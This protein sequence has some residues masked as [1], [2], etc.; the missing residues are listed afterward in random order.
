MPRQASRVNK[1]IRKKVI[2]YLD[3]HDEPSNT[4]LLPEEIFKDGNGNRG[5]KKKWFRDKVVEDVK[6]VPVRDRGNV[7]RLSHQLGI[8]V[9]TVRRMKK[10]EGILRSHRSSIK[11]KLT[12]E[13]VEW[14][15]DYSW[16]K[17]D[18]EC[19]DGGMDLRGPSLYYQK[20]YNNIHVDEKWFYLIKEGRKFT[21]TWDEEE[22][23]ITQQHK[24]LFQRS[25]SYMRWHV[26]DTFQKSVI[27]WMVRLVFGQLD[28]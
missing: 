25:C 19:F 20:M 17:V 23:Y 2:A 1:L 5:A 9:T 3:D 11:P 7:E 10:E 18:D 8:P 16:S 15:L 22:P 12:E 28:T 4:I 26:Q 14:R 27:C 6:K 13:N 21:L 24:E